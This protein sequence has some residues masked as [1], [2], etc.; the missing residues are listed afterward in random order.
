M[1]FSAGETLNILRKIEIVYEQEETETVRIK[2]LKMK[3]KKR[4]KFTLKTVR[5]YPV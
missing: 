2:I 4:D 1:D 3:I 5:Y